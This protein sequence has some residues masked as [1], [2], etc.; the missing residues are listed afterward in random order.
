MQI[1][2]ADIKQFDEDLEL[3]DVLRMY[4]FGRWLLCYKVNFGNIDDIW[5]GEWLLAI[6]EAIVNMDLCDHF[7]EDGYENPDEYYDEYFLFIDPYNNT[8][9]ELYDQWKKLESNDPECILKKSIAEAMGW[10]Y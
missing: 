6:E 5:D 10:D 8:M 2:W 3:D 1:E 9:G 4:K 7:W